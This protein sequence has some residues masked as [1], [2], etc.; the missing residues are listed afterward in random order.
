[1]ISP[2]S[3]RYSET[4]K[5]MSKYI[6][7]T[8]SVLDIAEIDKLRRSIFGSS[9][10]TP[11]TNDLSLQPFQTLNNEEFVAYQHAIAADANSVSV[12]LDKLE[13]ITRE[14]ELL[15]AIEKV[16]LN[17]TYNVTKRYL[18]LLQVSD[19]LSDTTIEV[20]MPDDLNVLSSSASIL[21]SAICM[22]VNNVLSNRTPVVYITTDI[23]LRVVESPTMYDNIIVG[24]VTS[25]LNPSF[26]RGIKFEVYT[27]DVEEVT[28]EYKFKLRT[29]LSN[30]LTLEMIPS[31]IG[32]RVNISAI[33][34]IGQERTQLYNNIVNHEYINVDINPMPIEELYVTMT[35]TIPDIKQIDSN[36][37]LFAIEK[38]RAEN[39]ETDKTATITSKSIE[40]PAG[41]SYV[42]LLSEEYI[43]QDSSITYELSNVQNETDVP[44]YWTSIKTINNETTVPDVSDQYPSALFFPLN[45]FNGDTTIGCYDNIWNISIEPDYKVKLYNLFGKLNSLIQI[46]DEVSIDPAIKE[47]TFTSGSELVDKSLIVYKGINDWQI[48][49]NEIITERSLKDIIY[50]PV[51]NEWLEPI[52]LLEQYTENI[53]VLID[54][55]VITISK[56]PKQIDNIR[57][58]EDTNRQI[59]FIVS[60][61]SANGDNWDVSISTTLKSNIVYTVTYMIDM[62]ETTE[63]DQESLIITSKGTELTY[64]VDYLYAEVERR[65]MFLRTSAILNENSTFKMDYTVTTQ[66]DTPEIYYSTW[67][68]MEKTDNLFIYPFTAQEVSK[69]N[70]HRVDGVDVSL[71]TSVELSKGM[72]LIESTQ[73]EQSDSNTVADINYYSGSKSSAG[74]E[75]TNHYYRAYRDSMEQI[76]ISDMEYNTGYE[77]NN[78]FSFVDG[79]ILINYQPSYLHQAML[80]IDGTLIGPYL[81]NK[82]IQDNSG[83]LE[84]VSRP[85]EFEIYFNY[86]SDTNGKYIQIRIVM[87]RNGKIAPRISKLALGPIVE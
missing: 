7:N 56:E 74:V 26:R 64:N 36:T 16:A 38:M 87:E 18:S 58:Q 54:T 43:P 34:K 82:Y 35:K 17:E 6:K 29:S 75:M 63:V 59:G 83:I 47:L 86:E 55:S 50:I 72:H 66:S 84:Y 5:E 39:S 42:S 73:P 2:W 3:I 22:N 4:L 20:I 9:D 70:F 68:D 62:D 71:T 33:G 69:G 65:I 41:T 46:T 67:I 28:I 61:V 60:S 21:N 51:Y 57:I 79:K 32:T 52:D 81:R 44:E 24:D 14:Y 85:E 15:G 45:I 77:N 48:H 31:N 27:R 40:M 76:T 37:Y 30:R 53:K 10:M 23:E 11:S 80:D 13:N 19:F 8:N 25:I 78:V 1:M 12:Y 49:L